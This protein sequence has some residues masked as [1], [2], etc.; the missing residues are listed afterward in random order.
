VTKAAPETV[1]DEIQVEI[2]VPSPK[3][4]IASR[5]KMGVKWGHDIRHSKLYELCYYVVFSNLHHIFLLLQNK[6]LN[7]RNVINYIALCSKI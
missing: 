4:K 6:P 2:S 3:L 1:D 5:G 7:S